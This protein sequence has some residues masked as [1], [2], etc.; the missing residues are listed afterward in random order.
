MGPDPT[1]TLGPGRGPNPD[2]G[3][4][5]DLPTEGTLGVVPAADPEPGVEVDH[6]VVVGEGTSQTVIVILVGMPQKLPLRR[7][8]YSYSLL[9]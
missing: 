2:P 5:Q 6:Q 4:G 8:G 7:L 1:L 9:W 3:P